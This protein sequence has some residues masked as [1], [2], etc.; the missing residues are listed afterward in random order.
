MNKYIVIIDCITE[1]GYN[2]TSHFVAYE[3]CLKDIQNTFEIID[4]CR[5][6][7]NY[8]SKRN[9]SWKEFFKAVL[10][11]DI[12]AEKDAEWIT[13]MEVQEILNF[14]ENYL[15]YIEND[16]IEEI[17]DFMYYKLAND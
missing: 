17:D 14:E 12:S 10:D 7:L 1:K 11:Y 6:K 13:F 5:E 4:K 2:V 9:L 8:I 3:E 16:P 15:P